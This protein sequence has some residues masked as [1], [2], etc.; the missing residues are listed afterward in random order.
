MDKDQV[1]KEIKF[2][3]PIVSNLASSYC[4]TNSK[5]CHH[6]I[7]SKQFLMLSETSFEPFRPLSRGQAQ[8]T[9]VNLCVNLVS[10]RS[11]PGAL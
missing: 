4:I 6:R 3:N 2:H 9:D 7:H 8:S 5:H 11:S 10:T 1:V